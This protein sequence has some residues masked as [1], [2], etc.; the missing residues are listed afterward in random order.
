[1]IRVRFAPSPTGYLHVGGARTALFNYLFARH[2]KGSLVLR[3]EDTDLARSTSESEQSLLDTLHWLGLSWDE[4]P[5]VGGAYGPYRQSERLPMYRARAEELVKKGK[6]YEAYVYPEELE[7]LRGKM[8]AN[9]ESSHYT[10][11]I[12]SAFDTPERRKEYADRGLSPV[13][14]FQ[15]EQKDYVLRDLIKGDVVFKTGTIGDFVILRSNGIP[16]YNYACVVDD[17]MMKISHVIRGDDHLSNT[18]RQ[19]AMYEAFGFPLPEFAHVSMILGQDGARLS[20]RHGATSVEKYRE[21]GYMPQSIV[22]YLSLLGWSHPE[23]KEV[24]E[25]QEMIDAFELTRVSSNA[26]I[27]D[28]TKLRWMNGHYIRNMDLDQLTREVIPFLKKA[29]ADPRAVCANYK[30]YREAVEAL[31][32]RVHELA[33]FPE[34]M[35]IFTKEPPIERDWLEELADQDLEPAFIMLSEK[36]DDLDGWKTEMVQQLFQS[37]LQQTKTKPR[38]F[39]KMLRKLITGTEDGP[40]LVYVVHL[41]GRNEMIKR[42]KRVVEQL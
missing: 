8:L 27:Y 34:R 42:I 30:W 12:I 40:E 37:V 10:K 16:I 11:E 14:Y 39:Y 18:L 35:E 9:K 19:L 17:A 28:E 21:I 23:G 7:S 24:M 29:H 15:M 20:K 13:I 3:I 31:R 26:A 25:L 6:A 32:N 5:D 1:M 4:G 38:P 22:N 41:L 33:E 2:M 36:L